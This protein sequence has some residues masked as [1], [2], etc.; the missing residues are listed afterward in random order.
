MCDAWFIDQRRE[1]M[2]FIDQFGKAASQALDRAKFEAEKFHRTS[3]I[4]GELSDIKQQLDSTLIEMGQRTYDLYRAGQM[5]SPSVADLVKAI[6][7]LHIEII[8]KEDELRI[9]QADAYAEAEAEAA[10]QAAAQSAPAQ[11]QPAPSPV[12]QRQPA[13]ASQTA[14]VS[15]Q[16]EPQSETK[17]CPACSFEMPARAVFCP[18]CGF[19]VGTE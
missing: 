18:N 13:A 19:R 7:E 12:E 14:G 15:A 2:K 8:K 11:Q 17:A 3:R 16:P 1:H 4:Q 6:D 5:S 10:A 9:A